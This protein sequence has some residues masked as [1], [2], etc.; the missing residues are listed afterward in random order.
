MEFCASHKTENVHSI[1]EEINTILT[2]QLCCFVEG[3]LQ[4]VN[5][6]PF[7]NNSGNKYKIWRAMLKDVTLEGNVKVDTVWVVG[8]KKTS[9]LINPCNIGMRVKLIGSFKPFTSGGITEWMIAKDVR[10][11]ELTFVFNL[12]KLYSCGIPPLDKE[13]SDDDDIDMAM[14]DI[15]SRFRNNYGKE[16]SFIDRLQCSL[17]SSILLKEMLPNLSPQLV[18]GFLVMN[19]GNA[20]RHIWVNIVG[21]DCDICSKILNIRSDVKHIPELTKGEK[22][23]DIEEQNS[24][25]VEEIF[26]SYVYNK[27]AIQEYWQSVAS[28][29]RKLHLE[30]VK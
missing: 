27:D 1:F 13:V 10:I 23:I 9:R 24:K 30:L 3:I 12:L 21:R 25:Y 26:D 29:A 8:S 2:N 19:G 16:V 5:I 20:L 4:E 7:A 28:W 15:I 22:R 17:L 6:N 18:K 14:R 11:L